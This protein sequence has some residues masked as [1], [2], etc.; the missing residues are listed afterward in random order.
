MRTGARAATPEIAGITLNTVLSAAFGGIVAA[1]LRWIVSEDNLPEAEIIANGVLGV[2]ALGAAVA[3]GWAFPVMYVVARLLHRVLGSRVSPE[4]E[5]VG[6]NIA[7]HG[8]SS[9]LLGLSTAMDTVGRS[10]DYSEH[11]LVE[12]EHGTEVGELAENFNRM[13]TELMRQR[14]SIEET[15]RTRGT[16]MSRLNESQEQ[17]ARLRKHLVRTDGVR[18]RAHAFL[19]PNGP[20]SVREPPPKW[21]N[22]PP[23]RWRG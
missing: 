23:E 10:G 4:D 20:P 21:S 8:A 7:E 15:T 1:G 9:S 3:I 22:S 2:R 17:D 6:L 11:L 13:L 5:E 14:R 12:V 18:Y 16:A 19:L